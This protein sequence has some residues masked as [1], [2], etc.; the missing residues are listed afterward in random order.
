[1]NRTN[2]TDR[3]ARLQT[4]KLGEPLAD[5]R[6]EELLKSAATFFTAAEGH[7]EEERQAVIQEINVLMRQYGLTLEDLQ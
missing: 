4:M 6:F 2:W 5:Q 1:M 3:S 7:S